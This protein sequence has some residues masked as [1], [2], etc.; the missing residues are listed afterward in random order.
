MT[1]SNFDKDTD[2]FKKPFIYHILI[3]RFA[4]DSESSTYNHNSSD[5]TKP[6]FYGGNLRGIIEKLPYLKDLGI[7]VLWLSPFYQNTEYHGYHI[8]DYF[9]ID[10]HFGKIDDL[11]ELIK[12]AGKLEIN[13]IADFVA[14]HISKEHPFFVEATSDSNS[15]YVKW[16]KF[17]NW[18]A[19]YECYENVTELP[20]FDLEYEPAADYMIGVAK[21][22]IDIGLKGFRLDHAEGP[23]LSFWKKF[24]IEIKKTDP[25]VVL[26]GEVF[27]EKVQDYVGVLDGV[28]DFRFQNLA[29][30]DVAQSK[31]VLEDSTEEF[32]KSLDEH[33][34]KYPSDYL[35]VS[36]LDSHDRNRFLFESGGD[37]EKLKAV[38]AVQ[39]EQS[40]P[41]VIYNGTERGVNQKQSITSHNEHGDLEVRQ[42]INWESKDEGLVGFVKGLS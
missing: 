4:I 1:S 23:P 42:P 36:F 2:W 39:F 7:S 29:V 22:W 31:G 19:Q 18:P 16:F 24:N 14:N 21:F 10:P 11:K 15:E 28:I 32:K 17:A 40:M 25:S 13:V 34:S 30:R 41:K 6:I 8:T 37:I 12:E 38:L 33:Y 26:I 3:D 27:E 9:K 5:P 35:L 20:E